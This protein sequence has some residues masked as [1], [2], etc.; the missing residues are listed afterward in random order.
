MKLHLIQ[1]REL[2]GPP[3][4]QAELLE[5]WALNDALFDIVTMPP[6]RATFDIMFGLCEP[7]CINVIANSDIHFDGTLPN[8]MPDRHVYCLSR[9]DRIDGELVPYHKKDSQDAWI[10]KGG[11]H[12]VVAPYAMGIPGCDNALAHDL[13]R[14]GYAVSNPCRTITAI[15]LHESGYRT[16]GDGRGAMKAY[17][18]PPPYKLVAPE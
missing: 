11:P 17:R 2:Y 6:P 15:H 3:E 5:A 1:P 10:V 13:S 16:Y 18:L 8:D 12:D 7:G 9:W 4:R 14:A